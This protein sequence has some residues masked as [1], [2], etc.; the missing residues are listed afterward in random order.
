M[1]EIARGAEAVLYEDKDTVIKHRL[2]KNYRL[3]ELDDMLRKQ[4]TKREANVLKKISI[5]HPELIES[6]DREKIVMQKIIGEK[7]RDVLDKKPELAKQVGKLVAEM[8]NNH[9]IHGDLTTSNMIL[10]EKGKIVFIDFGLSFESHKIEDKAVDIHLFKQALNSKHHK[11]YEKALKS[12]FEGYRTEKQ[13][14][15]V[16]ERLKKVDSRGRYKK[17]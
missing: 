1:R 11:V 12:F 17:G 5:P 4:R 6:D 10:D 7:L 3:K 16:L 14:K 13:Y 15:Y 9:I 8:H 2:K